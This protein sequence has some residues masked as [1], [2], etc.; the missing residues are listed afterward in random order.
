MIQRVQS[1]YL[2]ITIILLSIVTVGPI[3]FSFV[4]ETS[5]FSFSSYGIVHYAKET[6][7]IISTTSFPLFIG[8][9]ALTLLSFICL[10]SY[11]NLSRQ[12]K[13]GRVVFFLYLISLVSIILMAYLGPKMLEEETTS[14]ELGLGFILFVCGFPFTFL[15]NTGIKRDK[16]LLES[17]DRLR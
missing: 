17:L 14:R 11:K 12:F 13:L 9:I 15:A 7:D 5:V 1:I 4:N 6:G 10:M 3:F 8:T 16:K 2:A